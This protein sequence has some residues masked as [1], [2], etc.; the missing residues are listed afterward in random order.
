MYSAWFVFSLEQDFAEAFDEVPVS[1]FLQ[2]VE[3]PL[4]GS[5]ALWHISSAHMLWVHPDHDQ[6]QSQCQSLG[7]IASYWPPARLCV[8]VPLLGSALCEIHNQWKNGWAYSSFC[9]G[10]TELHCSSVLQA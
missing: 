5:T 1:S 10:C 9:W 6:D 2:P 4:D 7:Y 8:T 3:I